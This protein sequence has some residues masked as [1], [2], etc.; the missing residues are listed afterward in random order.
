MK[1]AVCIK[2]VPVVSR[3]KFD[4]ETRT[5]VREGVPLEVNSFD[6][7]AVDRA[8]QLAKGSGAEVVVFT[9]GPSQA[10]DALV[11]CIA[12]G[13]HRAVHLTDRAMAGSDTLATARTLAMALKREGFDPRGPGDWIVLCGRNSTDAETGQ[14]GPEIAELLRVPYVG[15]VRKLEH[16]VS[17]D[18]LVVERVVDDGYEVIRCPLPALLSVAEGIMPER[19]ATR[20]EMEAA[21]ESPAIE[22]VSGAQLSMASSLLGAAGSPNVG[23][24]DQGG[25]A[26]APRRSHRGGRPAGG[27]AKVGRGVQP[28]GDAASAVRGP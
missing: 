23:V 6:L 19:F 8:V 17:D 26:P 10:R 25:R 2:Q 21:R 18:S 4:Y 1:I 28:H 14:V 13:A 20:Q 11:Q 7:L 24:G 27:G 16:S 5:V 15:N 22:E 3:M 9:M 12:M